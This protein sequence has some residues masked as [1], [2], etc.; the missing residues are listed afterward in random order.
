MT[1]WFETHSTSV[2]N[3]LGLA[4]GHFD[5][6]LSEIGRMQARDLG[7]RYEDRNLT[8]V[9]TSDLKR[10]VETA[11]IAFTRR[12]HPN[13]RLRECDYGAW[14]RRNVSD[15]EAARLRF[16]DEPFPQ[17]ESYRDV[18]RRVKRFLDDLPHDP[19]SVLIIGHRAPWYALEH[20]LCGR[21]LHE[22]ISTPWQWQPGWRY[23]R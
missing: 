9:Y 23:S 10:S 16:V 20:L 15:L 17:G 8:A 22:V 13:P 12:A 5:V 14:T 19:A 21:D 3:E 18:V 7:A 4:S 6:E 11:A 1:I 2:D